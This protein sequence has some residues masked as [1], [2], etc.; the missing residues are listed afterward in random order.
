M[1]GWSPDFIPK[2]TEDAVAMQ[3]IDRIL[4]V[5]G[6]DAMRCARDLARQE[7][8]FVGITAGATFA[9][10]LEVCKGAAAG[11]NVLCML[12]DTGERYLS[13]PLFADIDADMNEEELDIS[14]ST[15][16]ARFDAPAPAAP[17][18]PV[19]APAAAPAPSALSPDAKR[20]V[21][22]VLGDAKM[23]V[24]MFAL[25]WCEFCWSARKMFAKYKIPYRS[26]DIDS[27]QYQADEQGAKIRAAVSARTSFTTIPQI[28]V[29][30]EF[31]GGAT[32][33]LK[34]WN[35]GKLQ[36]LLEKNQVGYDREARGD[37][38]AFLPGWLHK[39]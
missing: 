33:V 23:P 18:K 14:R 36:A 15:P 28:F 19:P 2:L 17:S 4:P 8:I 37:A 6:S 31:I 24:V 16:L 27:V 20:F 3:V 39:R 30:G 12:P 21:D 7:G 5:N 9:G 34:A 29:G 1:Q 10:A 22:E 11:S 13:T 25:E 38:M 35:E 26:V 32:D